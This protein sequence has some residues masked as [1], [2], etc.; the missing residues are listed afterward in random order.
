MFNFQNNSLW[1]NYYPYYIPQGNEIL[2]VILPQSTLVVT[3]AQLGLKTRFIWLKASFFLEPQG[4]ESKC[5]N[6]ILDVE[7]PILISGVVCFRVQTLMSSKAKMGTWVF[8][9]LALQFI[10]PW[11]NLLNYF[12]VYLMTKKPQEYTTHFI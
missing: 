5:Y 8:S 10:G 9:F 3:S 11:S 7:M 2:K 12:P 1:R 4:E 6:Y